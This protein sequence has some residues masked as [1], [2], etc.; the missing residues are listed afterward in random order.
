M[1]IL[2]KKNTNILLISVISI[3][4]LSILFFINKS[5]QEQIGFLEQHIVN[6][7]KQSFQSIIITR[8]WNAEH[9]G[10]YVKEHDNLQANPYLI[11]NQLTTKDGEKLI[12]VNPAWMTRQ[13]SEINNKQNNMY[14]KITS[15]NP[16]NPNNQPNQFEKE[17]LTYFE[18]NKDMK[19]FFNKKEITQKDTFDFM[20]RLTVEKACLKCHAVQGYKEGDIRGGIRI[21]LYIEKY[22]NHASD[23]IQK[24]HYLEFI[25]FFL[26]VI[27]TF[28]VYKLN[29]KIFK[30]EELMLIQ[31]RH[32]AM[33]EMISMI[34]HQW[35]Q[36][37]SVVSMGA[38]NILADIELDIIDNKALKG[39]SND[40]LEQT[41]YLTQ[42]ID[43]FSDFFKPDMG[44][45]A[46]N[47]EEVVEDSLKIISKSLENNNII[48]IKNYST[49]NKINIFDKK[50]LQVLINILK[51][52]KEA[53][54]EKDI[55]NKQINIST[56]EKSGF[57]YI[58]IRD[59]A[60]GIPKDVL[61]KIFEPY[62]STK[63]EKNGSGL[64]LY[65]SYTIVSKHLHGELTASNTKEGAKFLIKLPNK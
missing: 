57:C 42:T 21:S 52:A 49:Q 13:I 25:V 59:N 23:I 36:P 64:G 38:N 48:V 3:L 50:L 6:E 4:T 63:E 35:R 45:T 47:I 1:I 26:S 11:N 55:Q 39:I 16:I 40:I 54:E 41:E 32:A 19:Y 44:M 34:A 14:Y 2:N 37:I 33:G 5:Q 22:K 8:K 9:G 18:K 17:A 51:N 65:M 7:A 10:V 27:F 56:F 30:Q 12:K 61:P 20:G 62:F 24:H 15:L 53:F 31:S 60:K 29:N 43:D 46:I 28:I 58:E